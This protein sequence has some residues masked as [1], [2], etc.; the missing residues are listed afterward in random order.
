MM[1]RHPWLEKRAA[2]DSVAGAT[3]SL[4]R[5]KTQRLWLVH[6]KWYDLNG[7]ISQHPGGKFWIEQTR[8]QDITDLVET[9]H[10]FPPEVLLK[11]LG[12]FYVGDAP[13]DYRPFFDYK[14]DGFY[15]TL[16]RRCWEAIKKSGKGTNATPLFRLQCSLVLVAHALCFCCTAAWNSPAFAVLTGFTIA[17]LHGIGHNFL[18]QKDSAWM[19]AALAGGW[20]VRRNRVSHVISHHPR[21]NTNWDLEILGLEPWLYNMVDRPANSKWVVLYGPV[22]C[23]SGHL[24]DVVLLWKGLALGKEP[25]R[26]EYLSN[27]LQLGALAYCNGPAGGAVLFC[28]MFL[29][30]GG[31]D[32]YAGY[33][34]HHTES[35]WTVG[36]VSHKR[37]RDIGEHL[38]ATTVDY[39]TDAAERGVL[40][41][42]NMF[43]YE[44]MPNHLIHHC[45]PTLD[46][47]RFQCIAD[48]FESTMQEF[49]LAQ[50]KI[51]MPA[52]YFGMWPAWLRGDGKQH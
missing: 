16:K 18:H 51:P 36:D 39:C 25:F 41:W 40:F 34:L 42:R 48:T 8:G 19:F 15:R 17:A 20:K 32:S 31:I 14:E 50:K 52:I 33:P 1:K 5:G 49:G 3:R 27:A 12:K 37:K 24:L 44:L 26:L 45:F 21:P 35:A 11:M 43:V 4:P 38:V 10:M 6:G 28:I 22:L 7:F 46:C 2:A 13:S 47:S 30:F 23:M 9:H 29:T